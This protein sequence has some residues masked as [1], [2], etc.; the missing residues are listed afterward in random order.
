LMM[1]AAIDID[2]K[3]PLPGSLDCRGAR[4]R[5]AGGRSLKHV[6]NNAIRLKARGEL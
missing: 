1:R 2:E 3:P 4:I 6:A 5:S